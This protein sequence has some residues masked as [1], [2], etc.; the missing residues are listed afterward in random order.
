MERSEVMPEDKDSP[1]SEGK[2]LTKG[3]IL[4]IF[5]K[6]LANVQT[7]IGQL[8]LFPLRTSDIDSYKSISA[9]EPVDRI[10][11]FL[12]FIAS[13]SFSDAQKKERVAIPVEQVGQLS[14]EEVEVLAE[15]YTSS[16][17]FVRAREGGKGREPLAQNE[18]EPA[19][20]FL[21]RLLRERIE[22]EASQ[23]SKLREQMLGS[24]SSIFDQVRKSNLELEKTW[25]S[26][27]NLSIATEVPPFE[28]KKSFEIETHNHFAQDLE[29]SARERNE[30]RKIIRLTGQM[31][32]QSAKTLKQRVLCLR[33]WINEIL[34]P[35]AQ[36]K[37][38][39][40]LPL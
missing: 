35:N 29:R 34:N 32:A 38:S 11:E 17:D 8:Y 39:F 9:D 20:S 33:S 25:K 22:E 27:E 6:P 23:M 15:A 36:Q 4:S 7:S 10:R 37:F 3:Q 5:P 31:T 21:D 12:P 30:D 2:P 28:T 18:G 16:S 1:R 14:D 19:T 26:F 13:L 40:G 24:T